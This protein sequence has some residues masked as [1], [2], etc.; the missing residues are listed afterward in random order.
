MQRT[1]CLHVC[2][3]ID[4]NQYGTFNGSWMSECSY[5]V[6]TF[7][8]HYDSFTEAATSD[9]ERTYQTCSVLIGQ[10]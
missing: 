3:H 10:L 9:D 8:S 1:K 4:W 6:I 7:V 5:T 2:L